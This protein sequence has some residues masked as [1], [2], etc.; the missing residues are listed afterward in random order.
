MYKMNKKFFTNKK[1]ILSICSI[2]FITITL[3]NIDL[4]ILKRYYNDTNMKLLLLSFLFY[5]ISTLTRSIRWKYLFGKHST[6]DWFIITSINVMSNN[7][8]P[9]RTGELTLFFLTEEVPKSEIL[10]G[11]IITRFMDIIC[12]SSI[13]LLA[14]SKSIIANINYKEN[15]YVILIA[16]I[17]VLTIMMLNF[18]K[19]FT[20][21]SNFKLLPIKLKDF[22]LVV[23][24]YYEKHKQK[25][26]NLLM[27]SFIVWA[28][29]Y[30][31]SYFL[32]INIF[33]TIS[34]NFGFWEV[35][36][37][38]TFSELTTVL[39]VHNFGGFGTYETGWALLFILLGLD[40]KEAYSTGFVFHVMLLLYSLILGLPSMLVYGRGGR[41]PS[42]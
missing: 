36:F 27:I 35:I 38:V 9:A 6:K 25:T 8:Y 23:S 13:V 18:S 24:E 28:S 37:G 14:L 2:F 29:K 19:I 33:Q 20:R 15:L 7:I 34:K 30:I 21:I 40:G 10:S 12:I 39:P 17:T 4:S 26:I 32:A 1:I 41:E 16:T 11:L 42:P 22:I 31:S 3:I 5:F